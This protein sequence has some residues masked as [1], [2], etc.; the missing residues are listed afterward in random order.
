MYV[1]SLNQTMELSLTGLETFDPPINRQPEMF[2]TYWDGER[3]SYDNNLG[4][5]IGRE[6]TPNDECFIIARLYADTIDGIRGIV[7][8]DQYIDNESDFPTGGLGNLHLFLQSGN[9][10]RGRVLIDDIECFESYEFT[11]EVDVRKKLSV[12]KYGSADLTK[13]YDKEIEPEKYKDTIGPLEAQ[14]YFYPQ[15]PTD[16]TFVERLPIYQDFKE[17]RFYIYDVNWGDGTPNEFTS[18]PEQID[19]E[20]ALYHTYETNGVFEVT[21]LMIRVKVNNKGKIQGVAHNKKF[22]LRINVNPGLDEDFQYFGSDG[23]SFIPYKNTVPIIGGISKQSNYYKTIK[24]QLGFLNKIETDD[25]TQVEELRNIEDFINNDYEPLPD[26]YDSED[27]NQQIETLSNLPFPKYIEEFDI[28]QNGFIDET[29]SNQNENFTQDELLWFGKIYNSDD[30]AAGRPDIRT[31][32]F[33]L[34]TGIDTG[35]PNWIYPDYVNEWNSIS[36]IKYNT[37]PKPKINIEFKNRSDKL[38]TELALLKMENQSDSDLE[39][40]PSYM[41]PRIV[42]G[43]SVPPYLLYIPSGNPSSDAYNTLEWPGPD[44]NINVQNIPEEIV[45]ITMVVDGINSG[46]VYFTA[47]GWSGD[48]SVLETGVTY[49]FSVTVDE[50]YWDAIQSLAKLYNPVSYTHLTLPTKA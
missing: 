31:F 15:Y 17:G 19:E 6:F 1:G 34:R 7:G 13:Y 32:L 35:G 45:V 28:N 26:D 11:P 37:I 33:E 22:K 43:D 41:I 2:V 36:D 40:L 30:P 12:G 16:E 4:Y 3:W 48:F 25:D 5:D 18:E 24:R 29:Y 23:Y 27:V 9:N 50:F 44:L 20:K 21:G 42:F 46:F 49:R 10:F 14:F 38:K 39:V 8:I 47:D